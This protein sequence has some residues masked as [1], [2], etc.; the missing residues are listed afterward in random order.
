M[1]RTRPAPI[2]RL[3]ACLGLLLVSAAQSASLEQQ[4]AAFLEVYPAAEQ[5]NW[6]P[7][8]Q[9]IDTLR[10]YVLWP[11][12]RAAYLRTRLKSD[13]REIRDFLRHYGTLKPARELR[14]RY[15]LELARAARYSD[16]L[17]IYDSYYASLGEASLDCLA[18]QALVQL[19]RADEA[20]PL[21]R[22]LWLTGR[23]QAKQCDPV[24][25]HFRNAGRLSR[26][27]YQQR[28]DL[29]IDQQE[30][31]LAR[32]LARSID[33]ATLAT[34]NRW[35]RAQGDPQQ[36][37]RRADIGN[38]DGVY[39]E[40]LAY[41]ARRLAWTDPARG[42]AHWDRLATDMP[43][44]AELDHSVRR[45]AAL[46]AARRNLPDAAARLAALP[47]EASDDE[48]RRW[49]VRTALRGQDWSTVIQAADRMSPDEREREEWLYWR[50]I[51][52]QRSDNAAEA[53][54][55]LSGLAERRSYYGFL[56]A[57]HLG[58]DY[59]F[60]ASRVAANETII[61]SIAA[62][63]DIVRARELFRVGLDGR[64]RSEWDAAIRSLPAEEKS[65]AALLAQRWDWHSRAIS[66]A[67]QIGEYDDLDLRYPLAHREAFQRSSNEAGV[68][69]SWAYG[70]ARS[71]SLFM[72]DVR[73][74]A[75]AIGLMQLMPATGRST[76]K[77]IK[78][79][80]KG[81]NTLTDPD[82]NIRLGTRYLANMHN[83]FDK[84]P[85][86][87]TA[88]YNAGPSRVSRW[89][90]GTAPMDAR[91]WVE[92]IPFNETR[93][94][95]RRVL[96]SDV[97]FHWR[98]TGKTSRLSNQLQDIQPLAGMVPMSANDSPVR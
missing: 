44:A 74:S 13:D 94:Y 23:S 24:F 48:V 85:A 17:S 89:L 42:L 97:I 14:Y 56:A 3:M 78:H 19:D 70:V 51:A 37:L 54:L 31:L 6:T 5:G 9:K 53:M 90:P 27:L 79:P 38:R 7:A 77:E 10:D 25:D 45:Y 96:T 12:L 2:L 62:R 83:R 40:Q 41:A 58:I 47:D 93:S 15:S 18:A 73:S 33:D 21:A 8:S 67:A 72:P 98:L 57:D 87:A 86:L 75:G 68:R 22:R 11:D 34:A 64:A 39:H 36:F 46:W 28:H 65:Q 55:I 95:V 63:P 4:R 80:Y 60:S 52:L 91:I 30:F 49:Q 32:Y 92:T 69:E 61:A 16:Y 82:S 59:E 50:A 76:A 20:L 88:A 1:Q 43:F 66:V 29:A 81:R 26:D 84:H 71:E 35:L